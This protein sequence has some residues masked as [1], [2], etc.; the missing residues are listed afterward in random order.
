MPSIQINSANIIQFGFKATFNLA[1]RT[2]IFD[3]STLTQYTAGGIGNVQGISFFLQDQDGVIL[4]NIDFTNPANYIVPSTTQSFTLDLS[5]VN[6]AFLFQ[7]YQL[8]A[9]IKDQ[10]GKA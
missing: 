7:A 9:A 8:S 4:T 6:Y 2:V 5:S 10:S 1:S 3:T